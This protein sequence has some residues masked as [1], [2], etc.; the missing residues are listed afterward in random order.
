[1]SEF[2]QFIAYA[3]RN[4]QNR[5]LAQYRCEC[6]A[7][8]ITRDDYVKSRHTKSC[9]C[10]KGALISEG[11]KTHTEASHRTPEYS[12][13]SC[14]KSRCLNPN[15]NAYAHYGG[16]G[17]LIYPEWI[18][19]YESFLA[20]VG[21]RPSP[22]HSLDRFPNNDGNYAPG[23]VRWATQQEQQ[24]NRRDNRVIE[25]RGRSQC[26]QAWADELGISQSTLFERLEKWPMDKA[27][28]QTNMRTEK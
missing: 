26:L 27:L 14:M 10:K 16:R 7:L 19:S 24:R 28:T 5:V 25:F 4:A 2:P 22:K 8:F 11:L 23:N 1:M 21:R 18:D 15:V 17:I 6:G 13:W 9:G 3:G 20:Y 12:I